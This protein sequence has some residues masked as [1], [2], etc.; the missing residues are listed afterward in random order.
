MMDGNVDS[1]SAAEGEHVLDDGLKLYCK[2]WKVGWSIPLLSRVYA[3]GRSVCC[4]L[5]FLHGF[6]SVR[7]ISC[8]LHEGIVFLY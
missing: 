3:G 7:G 1:W 8:V 4:I 6:G 5:L 2:T